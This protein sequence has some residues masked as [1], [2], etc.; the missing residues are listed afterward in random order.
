MPIIQRLLVLSFICLTIVSLTAQ[1]RLG[2]DHAEPAVR[3]YL[4]GIPLTVNTLYRFSEKETGELVELARV[5]KINVFELID[6][7]VRYAKPRRFRVSLQG[8]YIRD[9]Q[10]TYNLGG[11]RVLT[12][13]SIETL[14]FLEAGYRLTGD[15][16][17]M[18]VYISEER[19]AYIEIGTARYNTRFGFDSVSPLSFSGAYGIM[20]KK[21][22]ITTPLERLELFSPGKGAIYVKA[23]SRP[24]RWNLDVVT[25][26][27]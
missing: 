24:K 2:A 23:I 26:L 19:E 7:I 16:R 8:S 12:I 5:E 18:D 15:D 25:K 3:S 4:E 22:F 14:Q 6:C 20:V 10:S 17:D 9:L 27:K 1:N 21:L 11:Q 13:L